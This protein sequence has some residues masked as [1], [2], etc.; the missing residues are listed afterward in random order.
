MAHL[1][2]R[3]PA[4]FAARKGK[5]TASNLGAVLG[6]V[7]YVSRLQAFR[8]VTGAEDFHGNA[9]TQWGTEHEPDAIRQYEMMTGNAVQESGLWSHPTHDWLAGSPD[10]L[11]GNEGMIEV[12]CPFYFRRDGSGRV[13][14]SVP[15]HYFAQVNCLMECCDRN[16]C[17]YISW[18]PEGMAVF[19]VYRDTD[20]FNALLPYYTHFY[21]DMKAGLNK[22]RLLTAPHKEVITQIINSAMQ[23]SVD[24]DYHAHTMRLYFIGDSPPPPSSPQATPALLTNKAFP[25]IIVPQEDGPAQHLSIDEY[26]K[27]EA[28]K[29]ILTLSKSRTA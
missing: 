9:A 25:N 6:Q 11:I 24:L 21:E 23:R 1:Q 16:W 12:K 14:Q 13:H 28:A 10:G 5:L 15:P 27:Y 4:W 20:T 18:A 7:S 29:T 3:T 22:P 2:Q 8:R 17:D 26:A 19:R